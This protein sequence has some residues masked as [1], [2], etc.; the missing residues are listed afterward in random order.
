[1][2]TFLALQSDCGRHNLPK[3]F[4]DTGTLAA[5]M[6]HSILFKV[7]VNKFAIND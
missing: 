6:E 1:M 3:K 2:A 5:T 7:T 4:D